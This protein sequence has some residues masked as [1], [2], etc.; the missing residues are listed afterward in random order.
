YVNCAKWQHARS[1]RGNAEPGHDGCSDRGNA[2]ADENLCPGHACRIE[3]LPGHRTDAAGLGKRGKR[4]GLAS[5]MLPAWRGEPAEFF[6]GK[7]FPLSPPVL[8]ADH[9]RI[10]SPPVE[11]LK[12]VAGRSDPDFDRQLRVLRVHA[13]DQRGELRPCNMVANADGEALPGAG[14]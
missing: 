7:K 10:E 14:N 13:R 2:S 6:F 5:A 4:Q 9:Y 12:Q 3:K 1:Q 11:A 8:P